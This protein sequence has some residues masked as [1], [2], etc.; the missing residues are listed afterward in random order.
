MRPSAVTCAPHERSSRR[1]FKEN[2]NAYSKVGFI[3]Q[4][5][6]SVTLP[7][8]IGEGGVSER[9]FSEGLAAVKVYVDRIDK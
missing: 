4:T 1:V 5:G 2:E 3:D 6:R 8:F 9:G 7:R